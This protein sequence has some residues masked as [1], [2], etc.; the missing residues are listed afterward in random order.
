MLSHKSYFYTWR[1]FAAR[2][3]AAVTAICA[4]P[5]AAQLNFDRF[6]SES[7]L[8]ISQYQYKMVVPLLER[9]CVMIFNMHCALIHF[10]N[11]VGNA[12]GH[13]DLFLERLHLFLFCS[14]LK[15]IL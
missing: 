8:L 12:I 11:S 13:I 2:A 9:K 3:G 1:T 15:S 10:G 7:Q 5:I 4:T 14:Y 6:E